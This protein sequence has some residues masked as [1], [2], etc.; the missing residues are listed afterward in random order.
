MPELPEVETVR[1]G[2]ERFMTGRRIEAIELHRLRLR[3]ELPSDLVGTLTGCVVKR[4]GRRGKYIL[5]DTRCGHTLL[6]HLGMT[7]Q[8]LVTTAGEPNDAG[9]E[10]DPHEHVVL[11]MSGNVRIGFRD[12][13]RFGL[14]DVIATADVPTDKRLRDLGP[15]PLGDDFNASYL[16]AGLRARR[17]PVKTALMDQRLVAGL[18]NI[19][20]CEALWRAGIS[21]RRSS[22]RIAR[23]RV[24]RLVDA[25]RET[26][27]EAL[28]AGGS[29]L[30]DY[31]AVDGTFG[32]FQHRFRVYG[33]Q[34][35]RCPR[36]GCEGIVR[37]IVQ[38][39]R[40][41]FYCLSCQK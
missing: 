35:S 11:R 17:A 29:S 25:I 13:R 8:F 28:A 14:L 26:L 39:G 4:T 12:P 23:R 38:A 9:P 20:V 16:Y 34:G 31:H 33:Q 37:R 5:V 32:T 15:E 7:G 40:S 24:D 27:D 36:P 1:L 2:L 41:S 18:G 6:C 3:T 10:P 30:R 21:P 19:Y 22:R